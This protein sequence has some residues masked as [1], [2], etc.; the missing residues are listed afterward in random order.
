V[1]EEG[2]TQN[3]FSNHNQ[4][5]KNLREKE[6]QHTERRSQIRKRRKKREDG[7]K[8]EEK[9]KR[10]VPLQ[11]KLLIGESIFSHKLDE[12]SLGSIESEDLAIV[13]REEEAEEEGAD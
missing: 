2:A 6:K 10:R 4:R 8:K 7:N 9:K 1:Q 5:E 11:V 13:N 3:S 12:A